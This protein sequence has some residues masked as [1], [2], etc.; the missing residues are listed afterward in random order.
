MLSNSS[1]LR[2]AFIF[3][4]KPSC[5][6]KPYCF[7]AIRFHFAKECTTSICSPGSSF[8]VKDTGFSVPFKLSF[9][10]ELCVTYKGAEILD[11]FNSLPNSY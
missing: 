2:M 5:N 3:V 8:M 10:P 6:L 4:Y 9:K 11:K 1:S 7:K